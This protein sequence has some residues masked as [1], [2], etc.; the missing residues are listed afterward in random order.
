MR[1]NKAFILTSFL[2]CL[3]AAGPSFA[4]PKRT[5]S[6]NV[7][8]VAMMDIET[9]KMLYTQNADK[10]IPPASL[11]KILTM[12]IAQDYIL[13]KKASYNDIV[14][15][16]AAAASQR[17]SRMGLSAGDKVRLDD[18]LRG[19][20]VMSGNDAAAAVA[21]HIAGSQKAFVKLMNS[22]AFVLKMTRSRF[23]NVHG[24][25]HPAQV[26]TA[27]D[28][29][30]LASSY[31]RAH[32][33]A[34]TRYHSLRY[35][36]YKGVPAHNTNSLLWDFAGMDGLKTGYVDASGYNLIAT[37]KRDQ[38][39]IL[40]VVLGAQSKDVRNQECARLME[41]GFSGLEKSK[42]KTPA[43]ASKPAA[44]KPT[45][46]TKPAPATKAKTAAT[47]KPASKKEAPAPAK[48]P[49]SKKTAQT[50]SKTSVAAALP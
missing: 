9:R 22:K 27:N 15:V 31:L 37:A 28:M 17:G 33:S 47:V 35:I 32:P 42:G 12:Y 13:K 26:T 43:K 38:H 4:A 34:I 25:P 29:L 41:N 46:T 48:S 18:L 8:G 39:R 49:G 16:S 10:L 50:A 45:V 30:K 5:D 6:Y 19:M 11:T 44:A 7:R 20:A 23:Y 2:I 24:L 14:T 21:E 3:L 40:A 36:E 1:V